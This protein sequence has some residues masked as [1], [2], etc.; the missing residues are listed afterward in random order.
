MV[1]KNYCYFTGSILESIRHCR[2]ELESITDLFLAVMFASTYSVLL[3]YSPA[4]RILPAVGWS[5]SC[6]SSLCST[7]NRRDMMFRKGTTCVQY[8]YRYFDRLMIED[9]FSSGTSLLSNPSI[10]LEK[11]TQCRIMCLWQ[12]FY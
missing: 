5:I 6:I 4:K 12:P 1:Q 2:D 8:C 3:D 7:C 11:T 9:T 10:Y